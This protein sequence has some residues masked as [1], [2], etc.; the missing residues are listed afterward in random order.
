MPDMKAMKEEV[1]AIR[2]KAHIDRIIDRI[3]AIGFEPKYLSS[4]VVGLLGSVMG[5][6]DNQDDEDREAKLEEEMSRWYWVILRPANTYLPNVAWL[7]YTVPKKP[8]RMPTLEEWR[9]ALAWA[10]GM[11][12]LLQ[13]PE[14]WDEDW[15]VHQAPTG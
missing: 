11:K 13:E 1:K 2:E 9:N 14:M 3:K 15:V 5:R 4:S 7:I 6:P 12:Q 10:I 8:G